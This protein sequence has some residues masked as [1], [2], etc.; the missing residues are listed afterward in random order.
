MSSSAICEGPS[1]PIETPTWEPQ[2]LR[3]ASEIAAMR[4]KS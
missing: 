2:S 3:S 1:G 4:M